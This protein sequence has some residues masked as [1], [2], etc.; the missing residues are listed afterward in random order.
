MQN[1]STRG[2]RYR[3][4][5]ANRPIIAN[6]T[7][8]GLAVLIAVLGALAAGAGLTWPA[9]DLTTTTVITPRG[10]VVDLYGH[11][12]YRFDSVFVGAGFVG[13]DWVTLAI[14]VP[15]L[16]MAVHHYRK[17][18][19]WGALL[20]TGVLSYFLYVYAS[21]ALSAAYNE[22]FLVYVALFSM[23]SFALFLAYREAELRCAPALTRGDLPRIGPAT[24]M[25]VAGAVTLI[26]WVSPLIAA[27]IARDAP[28]R[29]DG[30][31]KVTEVLDLGII[32]PLSLL[33]G[34]LILKRNPTGYLLAVPLL[35][36][37][38]ML[39]PVMIMATTSQ[40]RAGV[41]FSVAEIIGP[42]SGFMMLG[43]AALWVLA[44]ILRSASAHSIPDDDVPIGDAGFCQGSRHCLWLRRAWVGYRAASH[45]GADADAVLGMRIGGG[46]GAT[47]AHRPGLSPVP[48]P[49]MW[50]TVQ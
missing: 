49:C 50:Q 6:R 38:I 16:V 28:P 15:L 14:G 26:V 17:G 13:Q 32:V 48:L 20:L 33:S 12:L 23:S 1:L 3:A 31:T 45:S 19:P 11:G 7:P 29:L 46:D 34:A 47:R 9:R 41:S 35:G 8:C 40:V 4:A 42:I 44:A 5:G 24:F 2:H 25:F 22:L 36:L 30:T 37:I 27:M 21:T 10:T 43:M 39:V 18:G